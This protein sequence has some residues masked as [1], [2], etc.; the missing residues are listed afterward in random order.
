MQLPPYVTFLDS[1]NMA[2]L[3]DVLKWILFAVAPMIMI[4][5]AIQMVGH[6]VGVVKGTIDDDEEY[7]R[8]RP[9]DD[10]W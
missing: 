7:E 3:W 4:W 5:V 2:F 6:L 1:Q 10:D 8:R 9:Y